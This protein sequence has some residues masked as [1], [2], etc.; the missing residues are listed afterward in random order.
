MFDKSATPGTLGVMSE[1]QPPRRERENLR[2]REN[3]R[4]R[5]RATPQ[6][7]DRGDG[8]PRGG[9]RGGGRSGGQRGRARAQLSLETVLA[10]AIE[11]LD[12]EG[13]AGLNLRRLAGHLGGGVGS[14]YWYVRSKDQ[15]ISLATDAVVGRAAEELEAAPQ[16]DT[17]DIDARLAHL[18][19]MGTTLFAHLEAHP[20]AATRMLR[21]TEVESNSLRYFELSGQQLMPLGLTNLQLFHG[22]SAFM[23]YVIGTGGQMAYQTAPQDA[24]GALVSKEEFFDDTIDRWNSL[25]PEEFPF[26]QI[27]T[28][29][30]RDHDDTEQFTAGLD[31]ILSG[32]RQQAQAAGLTRPAGRGSRST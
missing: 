13:E 23:N 19:L 10:G 7:S 1:R 8:G 31:L 15:L 14:L 32:L 25:D 3:V 4:G 27:I 9:A 2:G 20:W 6:P 30:F 26:A 17:D 12:S 21:S 29:E 18:R 22:I 16:P 11:I 24:H 28:S 5:G